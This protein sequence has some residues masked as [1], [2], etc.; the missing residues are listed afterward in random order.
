MLPAAA[1][2][3]PC[4]QTSVPAILKITWPH[5]TYYCLGAHVERFLLGASPGVGC[6]QA[7]QPKHLCL[8]L[9]S[10]DGGLP[11]PH[12]E[13]RAKLSMQQLYRTLFVPASIGLSTAVFMLKSELKCTASAL[14]QARPGKGFRMSIQRVLPQHDE[15]VLFTRIGS[16]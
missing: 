11:P 2:G 10:N 4:L 12:A 15:E 1:F 6:W 7:H 13:D 9:L 3:H 8:G 5:H 16:N 14:Q